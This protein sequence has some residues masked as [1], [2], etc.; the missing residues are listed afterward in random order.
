VAVV[1][2]TQ[3]YYLSYYIPATL[4][5]M[6]VKCKHGF[7][8]ENPAR[9]IQ[10][11]HERWILLTC[12]PLPISKDAK[13]TPGVIDYGRRYT[14]I[15]KKD[16]SQTWIIQH[17]TFDYSIIDRPDAMLEP[18]RWTTDGKYV[19]L[20]PSFYPGPG[21]GPDSYVLLTHINSLYRINLEAGD[22]E[23]VLG[24]DQFGALEL[25]PNDQLLAYSE[26]DNPQIIHI[27]NM[28][29]GNDLQIKLQE[30]NFISGAFV[31][32]SDST[33]VV[34][35]LG[36]RNPDGYTNNL[37][38]TSI[39]VLTPEN[40]RVKKVLAKDSR[41]FIPT[42]CTNNSYWLDQKTLCLYSMAEDLI[43][44]DMLITINIETGKVEYSNKLP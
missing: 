23:L 9:L 16:L 19:Y 25:S 32:N 2:H 26:M 6:N 27:K 3:E 8:L 35:T 40:M 14:Q 18:Y 24:S 44:R 11:L 20:Y 30:D 5:A 43:S 42:E 41:I 37:S 21:G 38:G 15:T 33:K 4:E 22:F 39:F 13:W 17:N 29:S 31:W 12:S 1:V 7:V 36:Y 10:E 34:F 28:D